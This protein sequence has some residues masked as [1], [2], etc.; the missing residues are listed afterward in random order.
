LSESAKRLKRA[1]GL[2]LLENTSTLCIFL[3]AF[4]DCRDPRHYA[5]YFFGDKSR[6]NGV[7]VMR[8]LK[9]DPPGCDSAA[10][11]PGNRFEVLGGNRK[12]ETGFD[13]SDSVVPMNKNCNVEGEP[14]DCPTLGVFC[15]CLLNSRFQPTIRMPLTTSRGLRRF[16]L[17]QFRSHPVV[18]LASGSRGFRK[19]AL[20]FKK[21]EC[22]RVCPRSGQFLRDLSVFLDPL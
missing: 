21:E 19:A 10:F 3:A 7:T 13:L 9:L 1:A 12:C 6:S 11:L 22:G 20:M 14:A 8:R 17:G 15:A 16:G 4:F 5:A 18:P 2:N